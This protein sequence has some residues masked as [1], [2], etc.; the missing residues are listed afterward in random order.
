MVP[1]IMELTC[2]MVDAILGKPIFH[3]ASVDS[4]RYGHAMPYHSRPRKRPTG[5]ATC[6]ARG[7]WPSCYPLGYPM[8]Y[9]PDTIVIVIVI[10]FFTLEGK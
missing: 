3:G 10:S 8:P 1:L 9:G 6:R 7:L 5:V 2:N 4:L